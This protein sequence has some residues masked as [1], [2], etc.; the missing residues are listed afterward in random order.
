MRNDLSESERLWNGEV[1][2]GGISW[3]DRSRMGPLRGV[4]DAADSVGR[5]NAYMHTLHTI[6]LE[7]ELKR[8]ARARRAL[9][10]GC[11]TGRFFEPLAR[12]SDSLFAVDREPAMVQAASR[13]SGRFVTQIDCWR[14][15]KLPYETGFFD[16]VLCASVLCVT[17]RFLFDRSIQEIARAFAHVSDTRK[18]LE[19]D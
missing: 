9:D 5:R 11:G 16:F 14:T 10:F 7:R 18:H 8:F 13:Y 3:A 12:H 6:V 4:I 1:G 17:T 19:R 15:D 2:A